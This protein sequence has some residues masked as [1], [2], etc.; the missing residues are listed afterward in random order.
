MVQIWRSRGGE[1]FTDLQK[2]AEIFMNEIAEHCEQRH[3]EMGSDDQGKCLMALMSWPQA[4]GVKEMS[5]LDHHCPKFMSK[6]AQISL[7]VPTRQD[8]DQAQQS[9]IFYPLDPVMI[10]HKVL[11]LNHS[12]PTDQQ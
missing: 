6:L 8:H 2:Q 4:Q 11:I 5:A 3:K 7:E 9:C 12:D 1:L 10:L